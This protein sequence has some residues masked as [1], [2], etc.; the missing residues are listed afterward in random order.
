MIT[1]NMKTIDV[2]VVGMELRTC[3]FCGTEYDRTLSKCPLCGKSNGTDAE[4]ALEE[5]EALVAAEAMQEERPRRRVTSTG[6]ARLAPKGQKKK[7]ERTPKGLWLVICIVLGA[8]VLAGFM[9]FLY[10]M[11]LFAKQDAVIQ[12]QENLPEYNYEEQQPSVPVD[13]VE[14]DE[15]EENETQTPVLPD[16]VTCTGLTISQDEVIIDELG[17]RLFLTA[18][19]RPSDCEEPIEFASS[20]DSVVTVNENGLITATGPGDAQIIVSCGSQVKFCIVHCEFEVDEPEQDEE[21]EETTPDEEEE[22]EDKPADPPS[23]NKVDFTLFYPGE[24]AELTV[25][26][27]PEGAAVSYV[28]SNAAVASVS[29][30][31][32][33]T[34]EGN[35][36]ATIT[37]TVGDVKLTCI[38]RCNLESTTEDGT[39]GSYTGPFTVSTEYG[40]LNAN[41]LTMSRSGETCTLSLV[42][43]SGKKVTGLSWTSA[44]GSVCTITADGKL[45]AVGSGTTSVSVIYGGKTYKVTIRCSF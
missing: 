22:G 15:M 8:A 35:G 24:E 32:T 29:S 43:A 3:E 23:L 14:T 42:D 11:G 39:T 1:H 5:Q 27:V 28:S 37:V 45:K 6:G 25:K 9:Y 34:A 13:G 4:A 7:P 36:T 33:V 38:V 10:I 18:V 16:L 17:G 12:E 19:A 26:N 41:D 44:N 2:E 31:G 30:T 40:K 21:I 20:D